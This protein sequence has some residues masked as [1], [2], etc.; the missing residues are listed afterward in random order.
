MLARIVGPPPSTEAMFVPVRSSCSVLLVRNQLKGT[1]IMR[2]IFFS[3]ITVLHAGCMESIRFS[4]ANQYVPIN[5]VCNNTFRFVPLLFGGGQDMPLP[6]PPPPP[7]WSV[8]TRRATGL[9]ICRTCLTRENQQ[10]K[11]P[12]AIY[13]RRT[14]ADRTRPSP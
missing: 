1:D 11:P 4:F 9:P 2:F 14:S 6:S 3:R 12:K 13:C 10:R 8:K 7:S 5:L